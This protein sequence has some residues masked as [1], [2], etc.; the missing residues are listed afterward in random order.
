[1][2]G[3]NIEEIN[4]PKDQTITVKTTSVLLS[5][6]VKGSK[7]DDFKTA[8]FRFFSRNNPH[9]QEGF[10]NK[11]IQYTNTEKVRIMGLNVSYYLEGNDI[12]INDLE[13]VTLSHEG[14]KIFL[15]AKQ[16]SVQRRQQG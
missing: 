9:L 15:T 5:R 12:V 11:I 10:P 3:E 2:N 6:M 8:I 14:T 16:K 7:D 1:M 4:N 13:E